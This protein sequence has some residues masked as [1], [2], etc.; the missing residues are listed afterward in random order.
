M[1]NDFWFRVK[2]IPT[3]CQVSVL[4]VDLKLN[5]FD[6]QIVSGWQNPGGIMLLRH[7]RIRT[8]T[9][10]VVPSIKSLPKF[11]LVCGFIERNLQ[12]EIGKK[13]LNMNK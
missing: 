12:H 6:G 1:K 3:G 2:K 4:Q 5:L 11:G 8:W 10:P 9:G 7:S 13:G